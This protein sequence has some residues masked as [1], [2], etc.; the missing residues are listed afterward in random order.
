MKPLLTAYQ[1]LVFLRMGLR[2][3][4]DSAQDRYRMFVSL[5]RIHH[6]IASF[7]I[8]YSRSSFHIVFYLRIMVE[9]WQK[10]TVKLVMWTVGLFGISYFACV[11][12]QCVPVPHIWNRF[13]DSF[14]STGGCLPRGIVLGGTYL[15]SI[16]SAASDWI[17]GLLPIAM[18]WKVNL[19]TG[20]KVI[21]I[22]LLGLGA[23]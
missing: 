4:D 13:A 19:G 6:L 23:L 15:H 12:A 8:L 21:V 2:Y 3:Y 22:F 1:V 5:S 7:R 20:I 11:V 14:E 16:I 10:L 9:R 18:L 17:L